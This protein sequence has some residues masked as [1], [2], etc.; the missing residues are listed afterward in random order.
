LVRK[1]SQNKSVDVVML[2]VGIESGAIYV[3]EYNNA[4]F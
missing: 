4:G 1:S 3:I 2:P